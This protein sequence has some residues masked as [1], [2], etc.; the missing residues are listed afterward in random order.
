MSGRLA[1]KD[2]LDKQTKRTI[3]RHQVIRR[4]NVTKLDPLTVDVHGYDIPLTLDD[5]F[6]L[7]QWGSLY[8]QSIGFSIGDL[9]LMHQELHDWTLVDVVSETA[10]PKG[11]GGNGSDSGGGSG[12]G[13]VA[14]VAPVAA[15]A[16]RAAGYST[17]GSGG[18]LCPLD[19][20]VYD[21]NSTGT[22]G[23]DLVN[24]RYV[25]P[26]AGT[27]RVSGQMQVGA[28]VGE[29]QPYVRKNGAAFLGGQD[30]AGTSAYG[31]QVSGEIDCVAGDALDLWFWTSA[32]ATL[33][34]SPLYNWFTVS[35]LTAGSG[36]PGPAGANG[37]AG[38]RGSLWYTYTGSGTPPGN[39]F[40][41]E[42]DGD[43]CVRSSDGEVFELHVGV[44]SGTHTWTDQGYALGYA[45][46]TAARAWR[47]AA[48]SIPTNAWTKIPLDTKLFDP[49]G[50]VDLTNSR[51]VAPVAGYYHVDGQVQLNGGAAG[52]TTAVY[53]TVGPN[54]PGSD[55]NG[56]QGTNTTS[57]GGPTSAS[58]IVFCNAGDTISLWVLTTATGTATQ[59]G[60]WYSNYLSVVKVDV[61]GRPGP[62]GPAGATGPTGPTGPAGSAS[63]DPLSWKPSVR[64]ATTI[65]PTLSGTQTIDNVALNVGDRV[66]VKDSS[67]AFG[68]GIYIVQSGAWTR[69]TDMNTW[70]Q[71]LGAV[72]QVGGEG[73]ANGNTIWQC[74]STPGGTLGSTN[75]NWAVVPSGTAIGSSTGAA[76]VLRANTRLDQIGSSNPATAAVRL[77]NQNLINVLDPVNAQD[78]ATKNYVDTLQNAENWKNS[79]KAIALSNITLSGT[80]TVDGVALVAGDRVLVAGQSASAAN[81]IYTVAAGAWARTLDA[82]TFNQ[83]VAA[84]VG[85]EGGTVNANTLWYSAAARGGTLGSAPIPWSQLPVGLAVG[86]GAGY[87]TVAMPGN[88]RL[89]QVP[90]P[91]GAVALNSQN[92]TGLLD[93]VNAQDG[94]TKNYVDTH[95]GIPVNVL[96]YGAVAGGPDNTTAITN[97]IAA[98]ASGITSTTPQGLSG[99]VF[100]PAG[101]FVTGPLVLP[102]RVELV[103][104]GWA[105]ELQLKANAGTLA[106]LITNQQNYA[107]SND[108]QAV[109][110]RNM[111]LNGNISNQ[112]AN[113]WNCGIVLNNDSPSGNYEWQDGRHQ[114]SN[115]LIE[116]FTG[117]G[118]VQ[119]NRGTCQFSDVQVFNVGGSGFIVSVDNELTNC[120]AG[121]CGIEGFWVQDNSQ[122]SNCKAWYCGSALTT[123]RTSGVAASVTAPNNSW[124]NGGSATTYSLANGFG[125]G[126]LIAG[127]PGGGAMQGQYGGSVLTGC[128]AQDN[129]RS[130]FYLN[131]GRMILEN[132]NADSNNNNGTS[133]GTSGGTPVGS[134]AG[135]DIAAYNSRVSGIS[136]DRSA[137]VN[138]Q[139]AALHIASGF[140]TGVIE[141][142]F[143][144]SL[145]D[146]SNMPPLLA[147]SA[148]S[149]F[150]V[151]MG[152]SNDGVQS[153]GFSSTLAVDPFM[154]E[155]IA[156][157]LTGPMTVSAPA[158]TGTNTTGVFLIPGM[159][160]RFIL[161]QDGTGGRVVT[162]NAV[163]KTSGALTTT[164]NTVNIVEFIYDGTN[165]RQLAT[166][167]NM[168]A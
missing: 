21:H 79:T 84:V 11:F 6:E 123:S 44:P 83:H 16:Y 5:D 26:V 128:Y 113:S 37:A 140:H 164:L 119:Q 29:V 129:A 88:T 137:N 134:Y 58:G 52:T 87:A 56:V 161:R 107:G 160:L 93:P 150:S 25:C 117:D 15:R 14:T 23:M 165:W 43:F 48:A 121:G 38:V 39:T 149:Q 127:Q 131:G 158:L 66:L 32:A 69:P 1:L 30:Q 106:N 91:N 80:Q 138:H 126:F 34:V 61:G 60:A 20:V 54:A 18:G 111:R 77:N 10:M 151:R 89:N 110:V 75:V 115:V 145:N 167:I 99:T 100:F 144:G 135:F 141:L 17:P 159:R 4:A 81:G 152:G 7:S 122:L 76:Y 86:L 50:N 136:W 36:P 155:T 104:V 45:M 67:P 47:S 132:C 153:L 72:V 57:A 2:A 70:A 62:A 102:E 162:W 95:G 19:T 53:I 42:Q 130:G 13:T 163:F 156:V 22:G 94:A 157:T 116:S 63:T 28:L 49:G 12:G 24:H 101:T 33:N 146:G 31:S 73:L 124:D 143:E 46:Q 27:Y 168:P 125:N 41:G 154:G 71:V 109:A 51:Y 105:T 55:A 112:L 35:L 96:N 65:S 8:Q 147:G 68:N 98:A 85:V 142:A 64:A 114:V 40:S 82:A 166:A 120:D 9:V 118:L 92:I 133:N 74:T 103:G 90:V 139:A 148:P 78:G 97:A 59:L 108:A 3:D